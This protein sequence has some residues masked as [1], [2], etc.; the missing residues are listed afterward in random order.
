MAN[1]APSVI[2]QAS[3]L[4]SKSSISTAPRRSARALSRVATTRVQHNVA[5]SRPYVTDTRRDNA[6]VQVDT[7]IKLDKKALE[8]AGLAVSGQNGSDVHVSPMAGKSSFSVARQ[9]LFSLFASI[10]S[11]SLTTI[12]CAQT[13]HC[14]GRG[15]TSYLF[16][17]AGDY[18][19]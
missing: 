5:P 7:A 4:A 18:A 15:S 11:S 8:N 12:R 1:I 16:G 17:H 6:Q 2:K 19:S 9:T 3:R 14:D 10:P 13:G